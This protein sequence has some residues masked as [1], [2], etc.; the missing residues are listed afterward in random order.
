MSSHLDEL[1]NKN[2]EWAAKVTAEDPEFFL[3]YRNNKS[4][5]ISG[6][7]VQTVVCPQTRLWIFYL[8]KCLF[9]VILPM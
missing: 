4:R 8:V 3:P 9:I 6:L 1:F 7:A 2:R 5:N